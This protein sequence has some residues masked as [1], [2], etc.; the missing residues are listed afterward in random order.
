MYNISNSNNV[1]IG[2]SSNSNN[3]SNISGSSYNSK[4]LVKNVQAQAGAGSKRKADIVIDHPRVKEVIELLDDDDVLY[5]KF[6]FNSERRI[7]DIG[8][9]EQKIEDIQDRKSTYSF[10]EKK[11]V[12][13]CVQK[14]QTKRGCSRREATELY[15]SAMLATTGIAPSRSTIGEWELLNQDS[16]FNCCL[17]LI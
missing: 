2:S 16:K 8:M 6:K 13:D 10:E 11:N 12:L 14:I 15:R 3:S 17:S 7:E 4:T 1:N 9:R 5:D